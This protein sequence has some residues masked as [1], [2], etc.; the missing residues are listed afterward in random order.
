MAPKSMGFVH[1][2]DKVENLNVNETYINDDYAYSISRG[3]LNAPVLT[4]I[5]LR[6]CGL[7]DERGL[8]ILDNMNI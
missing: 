7:N 3:L 2:K 8:L 4:I 6:N 1:N 5:S